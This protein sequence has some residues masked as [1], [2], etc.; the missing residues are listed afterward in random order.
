[1][2]HFACTSLQRCMEQA[3]PSMTH[4]DRKP[5]ERQRHAGLRC[6]SLSATRFGTRPEALPLD[7]GEEA[8][9]FGCTPGGATC[10][11]SAARQRAVT[12]PR[13]AVV[14][15]IS[16]VTL[17]NQT[18][19]RPFTS[20]DTALRRGTMHGS[21]RTQAISHAD[22]CS[23]GIWRPGNR[24]HWLIFA[25]NFPYI[26]LVSLRAASAHGGSAIW[27]PRPLAPATPP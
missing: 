27:R 9:A 10:F 8:L 11:P 13:A 23:I 16:I 5:A 1:M 6:V 2:C 26:L 21:T 19:S 18:A 25:S 4:G 14:V 20:A 17:W 24:L 22:C 3:A 15:Q 7:M 12:A